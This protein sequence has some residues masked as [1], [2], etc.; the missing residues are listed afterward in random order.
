MNLTSAR[1]QFPIQHPEY[2]YPAS[3]NPY[4]S[5]L[6]SLHG[7][8]YSDNQ[9]ELNRGNWRKQFRDSNRF[10]ERK[11]HV[12][13][14][15]NSA[16]VLLEWAKAH[17]ENAYIGIDWKFKAIF[18][19]AEKAAELGLENIIFLRAH[20]ERFPYMFGPKEVD[21]L[22]LYFPDPWPKKSHWKNRFVTV[23]RL[24]AIVRLLTPGGIFHIKTDHPGYFEWILKAVDE[25]G[26][27]TQSP[28]QNLYQNYWKILE[29]TRD[30]HRNNPAPETLDFPEVTLFEKIFIRQKI[31]IQSLKLIHS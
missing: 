5:K 4:W 7:L 9:T 6:L 20:A 11:L 1:Y 10:S 13:I 14:G 31:P 2:E 17:P 8:V 15:C 23:E 25:C 16:H 28:N 26:N 29:V 18:R 22:C 3:K 27:Q 21:H 19:A 30:L 24:S 12:E